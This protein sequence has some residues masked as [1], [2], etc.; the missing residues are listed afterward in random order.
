MPVKFKKMRTYKIAVVNGDGV[1][2]GLL[3][4]VYQGELVLCAVEVGVEALERKRAF[5][6][7]RVVLKGGD[8]VV[9]P[10]VNLAGWRVLRFALA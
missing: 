2:H 9:D 5:G 4:F 7:G 1:G 3:A 8:A 6:A 10:D